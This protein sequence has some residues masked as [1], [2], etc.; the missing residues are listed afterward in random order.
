MVG[1]VA[2]MEQVLAEVAPDVGP[3]RV[4][5]IRVVPRFLDG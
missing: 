1:L 3:C 2:L 4:D 5:M